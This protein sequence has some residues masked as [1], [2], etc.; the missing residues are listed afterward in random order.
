[1]DFSKFEMEGT[2]LRVFLF[3]NGITNCGKRGQNFI[4]AVSW[5]LIY[6]GNLSVGKNYVS[7]GIG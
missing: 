6:G 4:S 1:M 2:A 7:Q 3:C 5:R